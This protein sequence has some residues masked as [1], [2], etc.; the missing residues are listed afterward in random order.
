MIDIITNQNSEKVIK[1]VDRNSTLLIAGKGATNHAINQIVYYDLPETVYGHYGQCNLSDAF[2][3]AKEIGAPHVFL[4]NV[5]NPHDYIGLANTLRQYDFAYIVLTDIFFSD[6]FYDSTRNDKKVL[7]CQHL[8]EKTSSYNHSI[9]M[10]TDK[11]ASLYEDIDA[12]LKDMKS[13]IAEYKATAS[14]KADGKN[15]CF[16]ANNLR[17]HQ[18]ANVALASVL[19][20][21]DL[22]VYPRHTYGP[23]IFY[24]NDFDIDGQELIY[25]R[26]NHSVGTTVENLVNFNNKIEP[27]KIVTVD[28]IAKYV[29]RNIDLSYFKGQPLGAYQ[30]LRVEKALKAFLDPLIDWILKDYAIKSIRL[31]KVSPGAGSI[32]VELDILPVNSIERFSVVVEG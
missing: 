13:M 28:R 19:C 3:L 21:K 9:L 31:V 20:A 11:H 25:F 18:L 1:E 14:A 16:V 29:K 6:Y 12:Y 32:E 17:D 26:S 7:Y 30:K 5:K 4:A 22:S 15:L 24:I 2:N 27:E 23:A 10:M 8:L